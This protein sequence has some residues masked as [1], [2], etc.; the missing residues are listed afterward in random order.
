MHDNEMILSG[1][2]INFNT[3]RKISRTIFMIHNETVNVWSHLIG[4]IFFILLIS[5]T[6]VYMV[7]PKGDSTLWY[8]DL[9]E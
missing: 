7:P 1:Y 8:L 3:M 6:Y 4:V 9:S 2:R 5:Y